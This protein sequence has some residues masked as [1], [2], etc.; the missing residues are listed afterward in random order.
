MFYHVKYINNIYNIYIYIRKRIF[1]KS[2]NI[3]ARLGV[4]FSFYP[5]LYESL[6]SKSLPAVSGTYFQIN[7]AANIDIKI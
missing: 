5:S 1:T 6:S 7:T 4:F 2:I 3:R